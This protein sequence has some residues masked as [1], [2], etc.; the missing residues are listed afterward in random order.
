M[1]PQGGPKREK[2]IS[3]KGSGW[4]RAARAASPW[5]RVGWASRPPRRA[6]CP[7]E[8][9]FCRGTQSVRS[10]AAGKM[11]ARAGG[12]PTLPETMSP[13]RGSSE[14]GLSSDRDEVVVVEER[15][16]ETLS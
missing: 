1:R 12:T 13:L 8:F 4:E 6:S 9:R 11:P 7:P 2:F 5:S 16:D 14:K 3:E 10:I 15:A